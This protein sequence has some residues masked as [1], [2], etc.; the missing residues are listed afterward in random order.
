VEFAFILPLACFVMFAAIEV[1]RMVACKLMLTHA[2]M[3]G[4]RTAAAMGT[5]SVSAV[6]TVVQNA[7]PMLALT[8]PNI[9]VAAETGSCGGAAKLFTARATGDCVR[10]TVSYTFYP[11]LVGNWRW[12]SSS[13]PWTAV[14]TMT[15]F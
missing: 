3:E 9:V 11:M 8:T 14:E 5:G 15:V 12:M 6:Q 4:A 2:T 13:K 1:G 10:V 7:A